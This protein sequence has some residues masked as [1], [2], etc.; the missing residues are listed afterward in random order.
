MHVTIL[1]KFIRDMMQKWFHDR[2]NYAD[3]LCSQLMTW[4]SNLLNERNK[5]STMFTIR[6]NDWNEFLFK[7]GDKD[8]LVNLIERTCS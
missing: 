6:L 8:G 4:A 5:E 1:I 2:R 7:D 3:I